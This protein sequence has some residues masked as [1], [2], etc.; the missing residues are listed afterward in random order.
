M[1][2]L[3]TIVT[4]IRELL[5]TKQPVLVAIDGYGGAGKTTFSKQI[6]AAFPDS[7]IICSDDFALPEGGGDRAR[8]LAQVFE[9]LSQGK[10]TIFQRFEWNSKSLTERKEIRPA[11]LI[12]IEGV[13]VLHDDFNSFF[14][15][16][17]WI[18]CPL[19]LATERGIARDRNVLS[20]TDLQLWEE[21]WMKEDRDYSMTE[22]WKRADIIVP[23]SE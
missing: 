12:I 10:S 1:N 19:E 20:A 17:I 8:M 14:D 22:P 18:D 3:T 23:R 21:R 11:G 6:Q 5:E 15:L 16:R 9:P 4:R 2:E 13:Q 7:Q